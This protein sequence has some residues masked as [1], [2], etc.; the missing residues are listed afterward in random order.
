MNLY[1]KILSGVH[2]EPAEA[3]RWNYVAT[4]KKKHSNIQNHYVS[5][6]NSMLIKL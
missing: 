5:Y 1:K 3:N 2:V 4:G 6:E